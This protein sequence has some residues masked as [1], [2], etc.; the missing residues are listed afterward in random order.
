MEGTTLRGDRATVTARYTAIGGVTR[1]PCAALS[2]SWIWPVVSIGAVGA[3]PPSS[4]GGGE[5]GSRCAHIV[6]I[7][8]PIMSRA[9]PIDFPLRSFDCAMAVATNGTTH[10]AASVSKTS[11]Q[12]SSSRL[13][14][15]DCSVSDVCSTALHAALIVFWIAEKQASRSSRCGR[16]DHRGAMSAAP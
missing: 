15:I 14:I 8:L 11:W 2:N 7:G 9:S 6:R 5:F 4:D 3:K 10:G 16:G 1:D 13:P 12:I